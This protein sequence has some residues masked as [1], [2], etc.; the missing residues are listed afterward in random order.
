MTQPMSTRD[1][2]DA[3]LQR[4]ATGDPTEIAELY[5]DQVDWKLGWP[6]DEHG[7]AVPWIRH[8]SSRADVEDHYRTLGDYHVPSQ[9]SV[10]I[11]AILVDGADAAIIG[12]L[13]QTL[14]ATGVTYRAA[15]AL[16]LTVSDGVITRHHILE[17]SLAVKRAF[18]AA[19]TRNPRPVADPTPPEPQSTSEPQTPAAGSDLLA[20]MPYAVALGVELESANAQQALGHLSW[21]PQ[22]CTAGGTLHGGALM[23]LADSIGAVCAYLVLPTGASTATTSSTTHLCRAVR[24]GR[25]TATAHPLQQHGVE[26]VVV[27]VHPSTTRWPSPGLS[28]SRRRKGSSTEKSAERRDDA[29]RIRQ[30]TIGLRNIRKRLLTWTVT[31]AAVACFS[32]PLSLGPRVGRRGHRGLCVARSRSCGRGRRRGRL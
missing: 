13:S 9:A 18:E 25:V 30:L 17:D 11:A 12:E 8:R 22:R 19:V 27:Q 2:V 14:R 28:G 23:G 32:A 24:D 7:T 29:V 16:Y 31:R 15:F 20:L 4:I 21:A 5:A 10:D 26:T 3:L 1:V 6:E